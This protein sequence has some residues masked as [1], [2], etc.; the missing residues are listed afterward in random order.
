M[1]LKISIPVTS[2]NKF[3]AI[4]QIL[5]RVSKPFSN[6]RPR[7]IQV[8]AELLAYNHKW[9]DL[10]EKERNKLIFDYDT[11]LAIAEKLDMKIHTLYTLMKRL[12]ENE[13]LIDDSINK[14]YTIPELES[15]TFIFKQT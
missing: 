11:R 3:L 6:L 8:Y 12:K 4:V 15:L 7:E 1:E 9:K 14:K 5:S 13:I 2:D 10:P